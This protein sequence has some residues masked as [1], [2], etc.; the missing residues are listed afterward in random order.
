[1]TGLRLPYLALVCASLGAQTQ[2][3]P[4][5]QW[6]SEF[7][8]VGPDGAII[9][10]D[11]AGRP[12]EILSPAVPRNGH[13]TYHLVITAPLGK[14]YHLYFGANPENA[15]QQHVY[16]VVYN[17][18]GER[19][20]PDKLEEVKLPLTTTIGDPAQIP[21]RKA[22]VY[23]VDLFI[24]SVSPIRRIRVEAQLNVGADWIISP[25]ELRIQPAAIPLVTMTS[26][27]VAPLT[28]V[29]ADTSFSVL[30]GYV[31]GKSERYVSANPSV[32]TLLRRNASEDIALAKSI[33]SKPAAKDLKNV[34]AQ[35]MGGDTA[36]GFCAKA[37]TPVT[38]YNPETYLKARDYL[39]RL[40]IE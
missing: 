24:P 40:A 6:L 35:A 14:P 32:R 1:M 39:Y 29:S 37:H 34:L 3:Y 22:D 8:R 4:E 7:R 11:A 10:P 33:E 18:E 25:L 21:A 20:I 17:Q 28:A 13:A 16:R 15:V 2:P 9:P 5:V 31:C 27:A 23:V 30:R 12:R 26:G 38:G 19:W 36:A